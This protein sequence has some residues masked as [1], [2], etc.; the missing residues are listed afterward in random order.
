METTKSYNFSFN[1]SPKLRLVKK[2]PQEYE[3]YWVIF[4]FKKRFLRLS[5]N[6]PLQGRALSKTHSGADAAI[7]ELCP[8]SGVHQAI[9]TFLVGRRGFFA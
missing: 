3:I 6:L 2:I 9:F 7:L 1:F 8:K 4:S 5:R